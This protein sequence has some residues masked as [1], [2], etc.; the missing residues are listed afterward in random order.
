MYTLLAGK[1]RKVLIK[2]KRERT[3]RI[4]KRPKQTSGDEKTSEHRWRESQEQQAMA[5]KPS[6]RL[7]L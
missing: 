5:M 4:V 2:R 6:H 3:E 1:I 7:Q